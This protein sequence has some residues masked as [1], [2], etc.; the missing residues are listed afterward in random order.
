MAYNKIPPRWLN[1][2]RRGQPV[3]GTRRGLREG[4]NPTAP[5]RPGEP[6]ACWP[7]IRDSRR[8]RSE[9]R[10][11]TRGFW[12]FKFVDHFVMFLRLGLAVLKK[13][14]WVVSLEIEESLTS[15]RQFLPCQ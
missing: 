1:C 3:A 6:R 12:S 7:T 8:R 5:G 2:P 13:S 9:D 11:W 14:S 10:S 4:S 15:L